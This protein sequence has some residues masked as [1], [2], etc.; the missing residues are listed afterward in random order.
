MVPAKLPIY[1]GAGDMTWL[2]PG[3]PI[4][5]SPDQS[6]LTAPRGF[7]Q[8]STS[9]FGNIRLGI[10]CV[11]LSTFLCIDLTSNCYETNYLPS[12]YKN[13]NFFCKLLTFMHITLL[14]AHFWFITVGDGLSV[15]AQSLARCSFLII[16]LC[17]AT[18]KVVIV[19]FCTRYK[20]RSTKCI[21]HRQRFS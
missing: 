16:P 20:I 19:V 4:R 8:P 2:M 15:C 10:H 6:L 21:S 9:F 14:R 3:F 18:C 13:S 7:S 11:P 17:L 12:I 1:S 5:I